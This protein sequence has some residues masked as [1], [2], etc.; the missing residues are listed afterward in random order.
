MKV[1]K[2]KTISPEKKKKTPVKL[3]VPK[4]IL[5]NI[6]ALLLAIILLLIAA[7][8]VFEVR[9]S[10]AGF[11]DKETLITTYFTGLSDRE[12]SVLKKCFYPVLPDAETDIK[13]QLAYAETEIGE[14]VWKYEDI[15]TE[16]AD[17]ETDVVQEVL[18]SIP[19]DEAYQCIAFVPLE[20]KLENGI[21]V[22]QED[23]YQFYVHKTRD[24]WYIA[25]F[26]Q[27]ARNITGGIKEDGTKMTNE[28]LDEWLTSLAIEIGSDT[29]GYLLVDNYW[30]EVT[31]D[32]TAEDEQIKTYITQDYSSYL[33]MAVI[34]DTD[35]ED[36]Q[37]Y[38]ENIITTSKQQYGDIIKSSG[39]IGTYD[40]EVQIAQ[41]EETGARIIVWIFKTSETD[42]YTHVI[43]LES[44][45]DYDASTYINTF[46]LEKQKT[47]TQEDAAID[48]EQKE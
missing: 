18:S 33:T 28:E 39:V 25:A 36:F 1:K 15:T 24:K 40:T 14:T 6:A 34:K 21:T 23:I 41:N 11:D 44:L 42:E 29:V 4:K 13:N 32:E 37:A 48:T 5:L 8:V 12:E 3:S 10:H 19:I 26:Q 22:L 45:S 35:V 38:S 47:E 27:T 9:R 43:T 16:W 17:L 7:L 2:S 46:H 31:G 30:Q 20:Q